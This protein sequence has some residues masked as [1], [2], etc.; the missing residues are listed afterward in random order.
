VHRKIKPHK[1]G[2]IQHA[3]RNADSD[4]RSLPGTSFET[5]LCE[6]REGSIRKSRRSHILLKMDLHYPGIQCC[7]QRCLRPSARPSISGLLAEQIRAST[8]S[9]SR[10]RVILTVA[11]RPSCGQLR[12]VIVTS[13]DAPRDREEVKRLGAYHYFVKPTSYDQFMVLGSVV[14]AVLGSG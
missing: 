12:V 10:I 3:Y 7:A 1:Q 13:S 14:K 8:S 11:V 9:E 6:F 4:Q 5:A 2:A